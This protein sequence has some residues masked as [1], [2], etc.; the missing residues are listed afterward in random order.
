MRTEKR[1]IDY[2]I[3]NDLLTKVNVQISSGFPLSLKNK[4]YEVFEKYKGWN[5]YKRKVI[6]KKESI[7]KYRD[8]AIKYWWLPILISII[9]LII[10]L[11]K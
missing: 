7:L 8:A 4:G 5:D 11:I 3:E 10:S 6:D 1:Y 2:L 9:A